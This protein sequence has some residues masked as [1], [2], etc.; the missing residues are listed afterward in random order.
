MSPV[1]QK[2]GRKV[3][4]SVS[5]CFHELLP[6]QRFCVALP[7][8][9]VIS[10]RPRKDGERQ[11]Q[12]WKSFTNH[13]KTPLASGCSWPAP[14]QTVFCSLRKFSK[15]LCCLALFILGVHV[16]PL[17]IYILFSRINLR[18]RASCWQVQ[19]IFLHRLDTDLTTFINVCEVIYS[20][21]IRLINY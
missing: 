7:L 19:K 21:I 10:A 17:F 5:T 13:L 12:N 20:P 6:Q 18:K 11:E 16:S 8:P 3:S 2:D 1:S 14:V 15:F 9:R 4:W